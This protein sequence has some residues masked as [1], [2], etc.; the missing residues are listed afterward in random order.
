MHER[1]ISKYKK[2]ASVI[3]EDEI[4]YPENYGLPPSNYSTTPQ[5]N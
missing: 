3:L 2:E 1:Y 4:A 5:N